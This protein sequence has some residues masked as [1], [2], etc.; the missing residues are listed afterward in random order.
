MA[1]GGRLKTWSKL[2]AWAGASPSGVASVTGVIVTLP[3]GTEVLPIV[4]VVEAK[5]STL[6]GTVTAAFPWFRIVPTAWNESPQSRLCAVAKEDP[7]RSGRGLA[8]DEAEAESNCRPSS[9][10]KRRMI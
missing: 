4:G 5:T 3:S 1:V 10:S 6:N 8:G 2:V 7:T 9:D